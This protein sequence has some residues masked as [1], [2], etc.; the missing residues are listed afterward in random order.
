MLAAMDG[1]HERQ[2][3]GANCVFLPALERI[4]LDRGGERL[5]ANDDGV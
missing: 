4:K 1:G 3:D 5:N 2:R